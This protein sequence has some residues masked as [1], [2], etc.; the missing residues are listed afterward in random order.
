MLR[1]F[2]ATVRSTLGMLGMTRVLG[3]LG[4]TRVG[5]RKDATNAVTGSGRSGCCA[6]LG[7]P[8]RRDQSEGQPGE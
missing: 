3:M 1:H 5:G 4:M 6:A 8:E 2:G 7:E